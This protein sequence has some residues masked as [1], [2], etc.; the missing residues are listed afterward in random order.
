MPIKYAR[1]RH[2]Y[3][4]YG[5]DYI[6]TRG[7]LSVPDRQQLFHISI[8]HIIVVN[9]SVFPKVF[10]LCSFFLIVPLDLRMFFFM[11]LANLMPII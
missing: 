5:V 2:E 4:V 1:F 9:V 6:V 10:F 11:F 3:H 8:D 7:R